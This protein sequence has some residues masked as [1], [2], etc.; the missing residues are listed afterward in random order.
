M[1]R[2]VLKTVL[3]VLGAAIV[4]LVGAL[5]A[6]AGWGDGSQDGDT[7]GAKA[8]NITFVSG[9]VGM[10]S[11]GGVSSAVPPTCWWSPFQGA[12]DG[13]DPEAVKKWW[14]ETMPTINGSFSFGRL[15]Y[16]DES[17]Y[18]KAI[19]AAK[20]G[21]KLQFYQAHC[22]TDEGC[23]M[24]GFVSTTTPTDWWHRTADCTGLSVTVAFWPEGNP[25]PPLVD[26]RAIAE[27]ALELMDIPAPIVDHNP[28]AADLDGGSLVGVD[29][30]FWVRNKLAAGGDDGVL[31][32]RAE[33]PGGVYAEVAATSGG[34]DLQAGDE[35]QH[36]DTAHST[37]EWASGRD[38][39]AGCTIRFDKASV[40]YA[41]GYPVDA[42]TT[43]TAQ[44][45]GTGQPNWEDIGD[46]NQIEGPAFDLPVAEVQ[47]IATAGR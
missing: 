39:R 22:R 37:Y 10:R 41:N 13:T 14:E 5:P 4:V 21:A 32:V 9:E 30:W 20:G 29:T 47:S 8:V 24:E 23:P 44:W 16:G 43:W 2:G 18:D 3:G 34:L 26:P 28:D 46:P 1:R 19:A 15:M 31:T 35:L 12:G 6:Q 40:G 36:C 45:R 42:S 7:Y 17:L 27:K 25:P 11:G 33:V 38:P